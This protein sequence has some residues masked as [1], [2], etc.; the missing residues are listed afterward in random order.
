MQ[1]DVRREVSVKIKT[2]E[3][4]A[5]KKERRITTCSKALDELLGGGVPTGELT[6]FA[7]PFGSGKSQLAFQLSVNVQLPE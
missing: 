1:E 6:E 3:E 2:L 4:W 7:G 5:E